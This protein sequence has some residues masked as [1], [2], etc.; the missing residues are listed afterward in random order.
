M[1]T[2]SKMSIFNRY[3]DPF[4]K[5]VTFKKHVVDNVF[6]DDEKNVSLDDGYQNVSKAEVYIPHDKNDFTNYVVPKKYNGVNWTI[7]DGDFIIKGEVDETEVG[8]I[9]DLSQ[10]DVFEIMSWSNKDY[11]SPNMWH[12]EIIG[13]SRYR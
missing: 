9:K 10:Y 13:N 11:G 7:N 6:W 4:T 12:F 8:G 5:Q 1:M 3:V 2:N